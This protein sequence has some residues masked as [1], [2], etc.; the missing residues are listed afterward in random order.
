MGEKVAACLR[1]K[2]HQDCSNGNVYEILHGT[3]RPDEYVVENG[4]TQTSFQTIGVVD[5]EGGGG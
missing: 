5:L 3:T 4:W 1:G 2:Y